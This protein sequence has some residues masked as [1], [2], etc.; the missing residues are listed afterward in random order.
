MTPPPFPLLSVENSMKII[1]F[2]PFLR[3]EN[4]WSLHDRVDTIFMMTFEVI[5]ILTL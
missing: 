5:G 1:D 2:N 3:G 4:T